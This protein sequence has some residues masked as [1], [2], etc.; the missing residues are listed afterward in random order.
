MGNMEIILLDI[1]AM[2]WVNILTNWNKQIKTTK[3]V[4]IGDF[5]LSS[6]RKGIKDKYLR[7]LNFPQKVPKKTLGTKHVQILIQL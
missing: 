6:F 4:I 7:S 2:K 3:K 5:R 1:F